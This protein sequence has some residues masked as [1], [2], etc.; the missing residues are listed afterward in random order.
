MWSVDVIDND[1]SSVET[2]SYDVPKKKWICSC[3]KLAH[4]GLLEC[5]HVKFVKEEVGL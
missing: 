2:V 3:G 4:Q 5:E 1:L